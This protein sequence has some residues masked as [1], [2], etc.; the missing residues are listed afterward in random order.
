[1]ISPR[2]F[3]LLIQHLDCI[4]EAVSRRMHRKRPWLEPAL[5]SLLCDLLDEETQHE[6]PL[7]YPL[8]QLNR[9]L[10][11]GDEALSV[12]F[13]I[14]THE[15]PPAL[16]RW[17]TQSDIGLIINLRDYIDPRQS[18]STAWL[19]Q[20]KRASPMY[21]SGDKRYAEYSR[22]GS[23]D[24]EQSERMD[25]LVDAVGIRFLK[26]LL[27]CPRPHH[28]DASL[29]AKLSYLRHQAIGSDIFDFTLGQE[30]HS[31]LL[32]ER[33]TLAAGLFVADLEDVPNNLGAVHR[34]VLNTCWPLAWFVASHALSSRGNRLR[35]K[36]GAVVAIDPFSCMPRDDPGTPAA[37][38]HELVRG[39]ESAIARLREFVDI[40]ESHSFP[41]LPE[42]TLTVSISVGESLDPEQRHLRLE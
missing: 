30:L 42:H 41:V 39:E 25:R 1:M 31:D 8:D 11:G 16:E 2:A 3:R 40:P 18:C 20:A 10:A 27:Y 32:S 28:V 34:Q 29:R 19:L 37:W 12:K 14:E 5:T 4:D 15:Y 35:E 9:D 21:S 24:A 17:V 13:C 6:E 23:R 22:F 38:A 33:S 36:S 26:L 7:E